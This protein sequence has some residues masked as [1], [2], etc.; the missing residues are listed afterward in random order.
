[1]RIII[2]SLATVALLVLLSACGSN[3]IKDPEKSTTSA[4][5]NGYKFSEVTD[6][7]TIDSYKSYN[8]KFKLTKDGV[9]LPEQTVSFKD[10]DS[11]FGTIE[12]PMVTTNSSGMGYFRYT[13]PVNMPATGTQ[14]TLQFFL[15][16]T[17]E[18]TSQTRD[19]KQNVILT[20]G[21]DANNGGDGRATTL[22]INYLTT[23]CDAD[24]GIVGHY[25]VHAVDE[26]SNVPIVGMDVEVSLINGV[27]KLKGD[28]IQR[29]SGNLKN[30]TPLTFEDPGLNFASS[31]IT[32]NDN[33]IIFPTSGAHEIPYLGG[34]NINSASNSLALFGNYNNINNINNLTYIIGNEK[35][36]LGGGNGS[37]GVLTTAH[38]QVTD[39]VT[40]SQGFAHFDI[41]FDSALGG[42]TVVIEAHG[43]EDGRRFGIAKKTFLRTSDFVASPVV[44]PNSG[45][46]GLVPM[47]PKIVPG[48]VGNQS[49]REVPTHN[50]S[51]KPSDHC[52]IISSKSDTY[53]NENGYV[54]I[55]VVTDGNTTGSKDCTL[56][57]KGG[58]GSLSAE[59]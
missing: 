13:P 35:R 12:S 6:A 55:Y 2:H 54:S 8:I 40:D 24:K 1:M 23:T 37:V 7:I 26:R 5:V 57:W 50:Y 36:I 41:V 31:G 49:L 56:S 20:F 3:S 38:I 58:A 34:W 11:K 51:I 47:Y 18:T 52:Y 10:F 43:D 21:F 9:V 30:T 46:E 28:A 16:T 42:H 53:A 19:L 17:S 59:Y 44:I 4:S 25:N 32:A 29:A 45:G 33:L 14:I 15:P 27:K 39:P 48:C 22:S